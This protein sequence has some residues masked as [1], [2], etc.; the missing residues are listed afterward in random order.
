MKRSPEERHTQTLIWNIL[1]FTDVFLN[2]KRVNV[3][4]HMT[5]WHHKRVFVTVEIFWLSFRVSFLR[6]SLQFLVRVFTF[7]SL[8]L[9]YSYFSTFLSTWSI[10]FHLWMN[11]KNLL[12]Y[13]LTFNLSRFS[14]Y[15]N[16]NLL[17]NISLYTVEVYLILMFVCTFIRRPLHFLVSFS[18]PFLF[19]DIKISYFYI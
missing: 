12:T 9:C 5:R 10:T 8:I 1:T 13:F 15:I 4:E 6:R 7:L 16:K 3:C 18:F 2:Q 19:I 17:K 11:I 14:F